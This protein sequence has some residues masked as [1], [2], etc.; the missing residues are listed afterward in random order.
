MSSRRWL[1]VAGFLVVLLGALYLTF[2]S[3]GRRTSS[4]AATNGDEGDLTFSGSS[5]QLKRTVIVPTLD[6]PI[7]AEKSA[8][9]C[10]SFQLAWNE[11]KSELGAEPLK[12]PN[13]DEVCRRL[14]AA[15]ASAG[16]VAEEMYF[17][18]AGRMPGVAERIREGLAAKFPGVAAPDIPPEAAFVGFAYLSAEVRFAHAYVDTDELQFSDATGHKHSTRGFGIR[19]EDELRLKDQ[20]NQIQLLFTRQGEGEFNPEEFAL[21]L[22]KDSTPNQI[23]LA[24]IPRQDS[25]SEAIAYV[26]KRAATY[27][28]P[29]DEF[30]RKFLHRFN[31]HDILL[32]PNMNWKIEHRFGE[33]EGEQSPISRA[34]QVLRFRLDRGGARVESEAGVHVKFGPRDFHFDRPF[35]L[36][37]KKRGAQHP[38]L[39][40]WIDNAE[41]LQK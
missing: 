41:L 21:D 29:A 30:H 25:L 34:Y 17:A 40:M 20:R 14:N 31:D 12:V 16:D 13:A 9:W 5:T 15:P 32:A 22:C 8:I 18:T 10:L 24:R 37:M 36:Y 35:L 28:P 27:P 7:P 2:G 39:A 26:E 33:L 23:V 38:F 1:L 3:S 6:T 11:L 4:G 19:H